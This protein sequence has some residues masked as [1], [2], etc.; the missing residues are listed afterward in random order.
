MASD[1]PPATAEPAVARAGPGAY[2]AADAGELL[3]ELRSTP[4]GL[5]STDARERRRRHGPNVLDGPRVHAV[6]GVL[7]RQLRNPLLILL[8]FAALVAVL[9]GEWA[10]A[11]IVLA[12]VLASAGIASRRE[13]RAQAA[14]AALRARVRMR[15]RVLRD[16]V[17]RTLAV[18]EIAPGDLVFLSAGSLVPADG[19]IVEGTDFHVNEAALTGESFPVAK[20]P[21]PVAAAAGLAQRRN[22]VFLGTHV[23]SGSARCLIVATGRATE[24]GNI[25]AR[26]A[27]RP[28]AT[29]FEHGIR[30]FGYLLTSAMLIMVLLVFAAHVLR[31]RPPIETLLFAIA[32]A[33]GL[34]PELLPAILTVNLARGA[35]LMARHGVLVRHLDA[36]ENLGSM[37]VLCT[38][39]T[40][41]LTEGVV[42]VEGAY[43]PAGASS[44]TVLELAAINA[45]LETGL[46]NPLDEAILRGRQPEL[47]GVCKLAEVPF[48][49]VR[50][51]VSVVVAGP[52]GTR[53][54][55]KGAFQHVL[56]ACTR[57]ADGAT[58]DRAAAGR[59]ERLYAQWSGSGIR[60]LAVATRALD[61]RSVYGRDDERELEFAGFLTFLDRPKE[62]VARAVAASAGSAS[63]SSSS[64]ATPCSSPG[65]SRSSSACGRNACSPARS[66]TS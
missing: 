40:G 2:W 43:D 30:R 16:G 63:R 7:L 13:Y 20:R 19:V 53:L 34:S 35:D 60:V 6:A 59:L 62:G 1:M 56:D 44:S 17:E 65:T 3:R 25:A 66:W 4:R 8:F 5:S 22:C 51:R 27:L 42:E 46:A 64:P 28:P 45:A 50:K 10:D 36:I 31:D 33:V 29:E 32:L 61:E 38:D 48:D 23:S 54:I 15:G 58:I 52:G 21:G 41:T 12:I 47:S 37:D 55:T 18:E 26:L 39:K 57:L 14:A 49:F 24:F 9:A 11:A